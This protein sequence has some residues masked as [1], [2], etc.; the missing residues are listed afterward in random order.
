MKRCLNFSWLVAAAI[1]LSVGCEPQPPSVAPSGRTVKVGII[2]PFGGK[3]K[4]SG[5]EGMKGVEAMMKRQP[6]LA[7]GDRIELVTK[8][9]RDDSKRAVSA[10]QELVEGDQVAAIVSF[11]RSGPALAM[12]SV[13][14][15]YKTPILAAL[16]THTNITEY[17]DWISQVCF[18]DSFQGSVAALFVRDELLLDTVAVFN[19]PASNHSTDLALAFANKFIDLGGRVTD[20]VYLTDK[21]DDYTKI[22]KQVHA[23]QPELIYL[24][25]DAEKVIRVIQETDKLG[26]HPKIMGSDGLLA[27]VLTRH[28]DQVDLLEGTLATDFY[29]TTTR[30]TPFGE[31]ALSALSGR[32]TSFSALGIESF[33]ILLDAMNRCETSDDRQCINNRIRS[34]RNF[35]GLM[36]NISIGADGKAH[37]PLVVNTIRNGQMKFVV[38]V[39]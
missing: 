12:A 22:V 1:L 10:L 8:D 16:A 19:D 29:H 38:K 5:D 18:D 30:L 21:T 14:D 26:W 32:A 27:T 3:D 34:T 9:G 39:Y 33:A 25:V 2:A 17:N 11:S 7:N 24:P 13:A 23:N 35:M 4:A 36:G 37:R 15:T 20:A 28:P 6:L 31:R